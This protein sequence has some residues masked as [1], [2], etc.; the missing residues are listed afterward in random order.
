MGTPSIPSNPSAPSTPFSLSDI[1]KIPFYP[2]NPHLPPIVQLKLRSKELHYLLT[3]LQK[4]LEEKMSS[5]KTLSAAD[6]FAKIKAEES[7]QKKFE[8]ELAKK[9]NLPAKN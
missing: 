4:S 7:R 9:Y 8:D 2:L 6:K 3:R 5:E 1:E